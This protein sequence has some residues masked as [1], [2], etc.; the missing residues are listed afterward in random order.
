MASFNPG[1]KTLAA[2]IGTVA[3]A[4]LIT[5]TGTFEG[6]RTETYRDPV[7]VKTVCYGETNPELAYDGA[8]YTVE[9]CRDML[10]SSLV[11]YAEAVKGC[12]PGI[13]D[14]PEI[15]IPAID[16]AYNIGGAGYCKS[17]AARL[18]N[19]KRYAEGCKAM[20]RFVYAKKKKLPGL[21]IRREAEYEL[22]MQGALKM[23]AG[24]E[25]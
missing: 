15:F 22:C 7:G 6:L 2:I 19:Q 9:E 24:Y 13:F 11:T 20:T 14:T 5:F 18:F 25:K 23:N 10:A 21:I 3:A 16:L 17:T 8:S 1:N 12:T 4:T